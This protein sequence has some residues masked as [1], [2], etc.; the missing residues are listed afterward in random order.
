[1][2]DDEDTA[3]KTKDGKTFELPP[4]DDPKY[5]AALDD[6][7]LTEEQATNFLRALDS[8]LRVFVD[9]GWGV[10]A[11][12]LA[13]PELA[14]FSEQSESLAD[15]SGAAESKDVRMNTTATDFN[16]A[17]TKETPQKEE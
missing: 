1:M 2:N 9:I 11:V 14:K 17:A 10:D 6:A 5:R 8:I 16:N 15:F 13:I 4:F 3:E 12:Q 7:D